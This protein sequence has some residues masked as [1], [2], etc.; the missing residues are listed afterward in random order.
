MNTKL[1]ILLIIMAQWVMA[2]DLPPI[3]DMHVHSYPESHSYGIKD[4]YGNTG[5]ENQD[6]HF[7]ETYDQ[8]RK[9]NIVKAVVSG[10]LDSVDFWK[11]RDTDN[12]IIRGLW[13]QYPNDDEMNPERLEALIKEG[14]VEVFGEIGAYYSG[15]TLSDPVWQ[16]YLAIC[17]KCDIPV[18]VHT[19]GGDPGGTHS[20]APKARL[21]LGDPYLV[22]DVLVRYPKL[23]LY[24]MHAGETWHEHTLRLMA[25]YP[26][27]YTDIA[28]LLWVE[29]LTQ[30]Y[31]EEFLRDAK[32]AGYLDRV[33]FGSDQMHWPD[34]IERS[35]D[36]LNSLDFLTEEDKRNI[37][38]HNAARFLRIEKK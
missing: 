34:A 27:L 28:V 8:F 35:I 15:T 6:L 24:L 18:A 17:E 22:E 37:L 23:R 20:W 31:A 12:R 25:Y 3:I 32:Q 36:F 14:K 7:K 1:S 10:P 2:E 29:P 9:H 26:N 4:F 38:Y 30:R 13:M 11:A 5:P 16:P 19:G 33:M 21:T